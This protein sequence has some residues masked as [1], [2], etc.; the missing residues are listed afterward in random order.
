[1]EKF[2]YQRN[3]KSESKKNFLGC[4]I[5]TLVHKDRYISTPVSL[6]A[7]G[8]QVLNYI[9]CETKDDCEREVKEFQN[10]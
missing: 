8:W 9:F 6:T 4:V 1:M 2:A 3:L 5:A 10:Q 7:I